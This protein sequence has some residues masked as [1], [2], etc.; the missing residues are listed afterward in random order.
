M[1]NGQA[2]I[3]RPGE[4]LYDAATRYNSIPVANLVTLSTGTSQLDDYSYHPEDI[5]SEDE[6]SDSDSDSD[7]GPYRKYAFQAKRQLYHPTSYQAEEYYDPPYQV[8]PAE[9]TPI[10]RSTEA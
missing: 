2:I 8:Y 5:D 1:R 7:D 3:R 6:Y 9:R 4:S 10:K